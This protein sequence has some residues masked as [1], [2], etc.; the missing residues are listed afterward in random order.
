MLEADAAEVAMA[1][2]IGGSV[3]LSNHD[4]GRGGG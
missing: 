3:R 1:R 4:L 2:Q